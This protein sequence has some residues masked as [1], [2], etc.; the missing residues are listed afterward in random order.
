MRLAYADAQ[1]F[2]ADPSVTKVPVEELLSP[3]RP[4]LW[5]VTDLQK[6]LAERAKLFDPKKATAQYY[7]GNPIPSSDTVY[8]AT[9]DAAGNAVSSES[10]PE[11]KLM[12]VIMSNYAGFGAAIV[13]KDC[14]FSLQ[15]RGVGFILNDQTHPNRYEPSKR[16][17][18]TIIRT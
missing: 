18:H 9:A 16:P 7:N 14:G 1:Q 2:I 5:P 4:R 11:D 15:N 10:D 13:P 12:A 17:Y 3:V 6:Y 8:F